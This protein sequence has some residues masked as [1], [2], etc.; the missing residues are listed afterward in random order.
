MKDGDDAATRTGLES[1][2]PIIE[3]AQLYLPRIGILCPSIEKS[4]ER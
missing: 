3:K 1:R 4:S 2:P